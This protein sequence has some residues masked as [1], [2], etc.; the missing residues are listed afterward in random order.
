MIVSLVK[1][2][3]PGRYGPQASSDRR[4]AATRTPYATTNPMRHGLPVLLLATLPLLPASTPVAA[5]ST[6]LPKA[7]APFVPLAEVY[8]SEQAPW[9][10]A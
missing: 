1:T 9:S 10:A 6:I 8:D 7:A 5:D 3:T 4:A 2:T